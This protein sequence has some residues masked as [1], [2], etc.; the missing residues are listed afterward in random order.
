MNI[1]EVLI[2]S[3]VMMPF[4]TTSDLLVKVIIKMLSGY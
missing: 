4:S 1:D 2:T 3:S